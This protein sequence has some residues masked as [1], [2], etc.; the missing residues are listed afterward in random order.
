MSKDL[1][2][3]GSTGSIGKSALKVV[4]NYP[5]KFNIIGLSC[6]N[7]LKEIH[8]QIELFKPGIVV[9]TDDNVNISEFN[10]IKDAHQNTEFLLGY[11]N[12]KILVEQNHDILISA[13]VGAAGLVPTFHAIPFTKRIAL[14]NKETMVTAG[15]LFKNEIKKYGCELIPV[16]SEHSA[17]FSLL[18]KEKR[19]NLNKIIITASGGALRNLTYE[20]LKSV[21]PKDALN[22]PNWDMGNKITIDSATLINKGLEVIEAHFLFDI[23]Y[24][25]ISVVIHP[26]SVIHSMIETIDGAI[27]AH[28][29]VTD[30]VFPILYSLT[31]PDK[32][33]NNFGHLN[34]EQ[35]SKLTFKKYDSKKF[36]GLNLCFESGKAGGIMPTVLNAANEIAVKFFLNEKI[37]F[38]DIINVIDEAMNHYKNFEPACLDEILEADRNTRDIAEKL[39]LEKYLCQ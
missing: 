28:M 4:K 15:R 23:D 1:I 2:I 11:D 34:L 16:D 12:L 32:I 9:I 29:G 37:K 35:I 17:I 21:K 31:Y 20:E 14:A 30:M 38:I 13:I 18:Q 22:H 24:E 27:Y 8:N 26:E 19:E 5:E 33:E 7:N 36:P 25:K 39:I 3:L 10:E 6:R